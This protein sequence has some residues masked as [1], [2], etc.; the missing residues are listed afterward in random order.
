MVYTIRTVDP[1][2]TKAAA[3][4]FDD[5]LI[6]TFIDK[7]GLQHSM[8]DQAKT[9][10]TLP[11]RMSGMGF[12]KMALTADGAFLSGIATACKAIKAV[13]TAEDIATIS[14]P[15]SDFMTTVSRLLRTCRE[16]LEY[17]NDRDQKERKTADRLPARAS[18]FL[19][20]F[21]E[22]DGDPH[23]LQ[24]DITASIEARVHDRLTA[25]AS[26][27]TQ[28]ALLSSSAPNASAFLDG[29]SNYDICRMDNLTSR[30]AIR[31]RLGLRPVDNMPRKCICKAKGNPFDADPNHVLVC[32]EFS[33]TLTENRHHPAVKCLARAIRLTDC[34]VQVE[35][36][37][38]GN[39]T[40]ERPDLVLVTPDETI[41]VDFTCRQPASKTGIR[42]GAHKK[43]GTMANSGER[44]KHLH[45]RER[46]GRDIGCR[47][48]A[49]GAETYGCLGDEAKQFI[50]LVQGLSK[51]AGPEAYAAVHRE[52][53]T[54]LSLAIQRGNAIA[55]VTGMH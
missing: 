53:T 25:A 17:G 19:D 45:Y 40:E 44:K 3:E 1:R 5:M 4:Q 43:R 20:F 36:V 26:Q 2:A 42:E 47:F 28:A 8:T 35:P 16:H 38:Y 27:L 31:L 18:D 12:R 34:S 54:N 50:E 39:D 10:A 52:L 11:L 22:G 21:T 24:R 6:Q 14:Q 13:F 32:P 7:Y 33:D 15:G 23:E 49:F 48:V 46:L 29:S 30:A 51:F 9:L 41:A 55:L 37:G